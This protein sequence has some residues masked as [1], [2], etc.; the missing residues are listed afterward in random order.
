MNLAQK[1]G[2]LARVA[3]ATDALIARLLGRVAG[4]LEIVPTGLDVGV[5]LF[6]HLFATA[7]AEAELPGNG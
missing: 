5:Q 3:K 2:N 6:H 1:I 7:A 4:K